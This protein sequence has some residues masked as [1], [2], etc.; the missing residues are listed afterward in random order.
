MITPY[1]V[2]VTYSKR[3]SEAITK[4]KALWDKPVPSTK[5][6]VTYAVIKRV[7]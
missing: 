2:P 6:T 7:R 1:E 5:L 3:I 4:A